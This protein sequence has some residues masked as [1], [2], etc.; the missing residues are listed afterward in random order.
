MGRN[1][2]NGRFEVLDK[3][4]YIHSSVSTLFG[5]CTT[6]TTC[7]TAKGLTSRSMTFQA[8]QN[9]PCKLSSAINFSQ[10]T[11]NFI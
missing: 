10:Q 7:G 1:P 11:I 3:L 6:G 5:Q 4:A 9:A 8:V 2:P